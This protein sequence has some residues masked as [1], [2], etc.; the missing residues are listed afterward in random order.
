MTL[1]GKE[2][3]LTALEHK[4]PDRAPFDLGGSFVTTLNVAAY[5]RLRRALGLPD[6][7]QLIREQSQSVLVD[8]DVRQALGVDV[9]GIFER[10]PDPEKEIPSAA[11][12]LVSEW[13]VTYRKA[14]GFGGHY[15]LVASPLQNATLADLENYPSP[16]PL[17]PQRFAGIAE[18][19][20][21]LR[22]S[23][24]AVVGNL[25]WTEIF[26]MAWYLR[27]FE[28]FMLDLA[29][30]KE[31]AHALLRRVTDFQKARYAR[32]L[33]LAGHALDV[34]LV[35]DDMGGQDGLFISP[36]TYREMI[37]PYHAELLA[38]IQTRTRARVMFHSC[39]SVVPLLDDFIEVGMD[40]LNPVQV[41]ARGMDTAELKKRYGARISFWGA[42][43]TQRVLPFGSPDDVRAEVRRRVADLAT[44]G[45]YVIA[46]V[47][48]IQADVAAEN[49]RALADWRLR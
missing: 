45:G 9:I 30:N 49:V 47:H 25:G 29:A 11:G 40:I 28:T 16:D 42:I 27:G 23:P 3:V 21:T 4:Q 41:A 37:K 5:A 15:T 33:E 22:E 17:A 18:Q 8:E 6:R 1:I 31:M 26:G 44:E 20:A 35:C 48:V 10:A 2:R 32:L 36:R 46:P 7:W 34:I 14:A 38:L 13:G 24:Y 12:V 43:D 39:G 19:A